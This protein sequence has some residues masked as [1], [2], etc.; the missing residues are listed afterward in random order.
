[1]QTQ[2]LAVPVPAS[3]PEWGWNG[4]GEIVYARTYARQVP[5]VGRRENWP[6]TVDRVIGGGLMID[7]GWTDQET[8]DAHRL[9]SELRAS[10][11]GRALWQLGTPMVDLF[12]GDSLVN[13]WATGVSTV[14]DF[15]WAMDRLMV[16]GGVGYSLERSLIHDLPRVR[17]LDKAITHERTD[18]ADHIVPD[19]RQGWSNVL[20]MVIKAYLYTGRGFTW[21]TMLIRP[22]GTPLKTFGGTASGPAA[23]I[24]GIDDIVEVF[25]A[26]VGKKF[27]SVD[28]LDV[29]NIVGRLVVAGSARRS[30]QI[31]MGDPDDVLFLRAK[32]WDRETIPAWREHSNNTLVV[33]SYDHIPGEFWIP[34]ET[35]K[36]EAYGLFNR[37]LSQRE[38]RVGEPK[39]DP[40]VL[41]TNPCGEVPL[42]PREACNLAT[43]CLPRLR[44]YEE[45]ET[46]ITVLYKLQKATAC[47]PYPDKSSQEI[48]HRNMRL[49]MSVTGYLQATDEQRE[50]LSHGY[51]YLRDLDRRWSAKRG[52]PES[53]KL[54]AIQPSG[55]WS[56][57]PGV[58]AGA[59]AAHAE[60]YIRRVRFGVNDDL[61][62]VCR[63]RGYHVCYDVGLDGRENRSKL[64]VEF[65]CWTPDGVPLISKQSALEQLE[66][67]ARL[68]REWADNAVSVTV[69]YR[70]EELHEIRTWL[71]S[72]F[73]TQVKSVSFNLYD[74]GNWPLMPY[75]AITEHRYEQLTAGL[76]L[77]VPLGNRMG[78]DPVPFDADC[79]G[80]SWPVR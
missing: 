11:S 79:G 47:L 18:D 34:Y 37:R 71:E 44:T 5:G 27:R 64:V 61:V 69:S 53:I 56:L 42:A 67:M 75:E 77:S 35:G 36:G 46:A 39:P 66:V 16:G 65:P 30:A 54:S 51:E 33:D 4:M 57:M 68:Q 26:R 74:E 40:S 28:C 50:W 45:F 59:H 73:D 49:G 55:S 8:A 1:M 32:R 13:C 72:N 21:S 25:E 3:T 63:R 43:L 78:E 17:D 2:T 48:I 20:R 60:F 80:G 52:L 29:L 19:K 31:A 58:T 38:G 15:V 76:D 70:R 24:D 12:G 7:P 6:E 22:E 14:D 62:D 9:L 23:L 41:V 10:P